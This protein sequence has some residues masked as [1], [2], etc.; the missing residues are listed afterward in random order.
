MLSTLRHVKH[1][2][3][4]M[5][6]LNIGTFLTSASGKAELHKP[7]VEPKFIVEDPRISLDR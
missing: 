7:L 4:K 1:A 3:L 5:A 2:C 6:Y